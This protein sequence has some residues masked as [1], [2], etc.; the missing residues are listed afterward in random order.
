MNQS[1][2]KYADQIRDKWVSSAQKG[3]S[4]VAG[5]EWAGRLSFVQT[6]HG[7]AILIGVGLVFAIGLVWYRSSALSGGDGSP[8]YTVSQGDLRVQVRERGTLRALRNILISTEIS[9]EAAKVV[10]IVQEGTYVQ[11]G[12]RV[13]EFDKTLF[14]QRID[15]FETELIHTRAELVQA[16]E[17]LRAE[18]AR[19]EQSLKRSED[20]IIL[21]ELNLKDLQEGSGPLK[22]ERAKFEVERAKSKYDTLKKNYE[23]FRLLVKDGYVSQAEVDAISNDLREQEAVLAFAEA[24]YE[25]LIK[26]S[27]PSQVE[28][29]KARVRAAR[30]SVEKL[31]QTSEYTMASRAAGVQ[32]ASGMIQALDFK[33]SMARDEVKRS[34][35]RAPIDGFVIY[36]EIFF[37]SSSEKR[38]IEI[39]DLVLNTQNII[40]IPDTSQM[41]VDIQIREVDIYKIKDSQEVAVRVDAYPDLVLTGKVT[42]IGTLAVERSQE[43]LGGKYFNLQ[44]LLEDTDPRL[45]PGMTAR[46]EILVA[47]E[48][49]VL[50]VPIEAVS[51]SYGKKTVLVSTSDGI[52]QRV[53]E[54]GLSNEDYVSVTR[55]LKL[56]EKVMLVNP[57]QGLR[58]FDSSS[59]ISAVPAV[60]QENRQPDESPNHAP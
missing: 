16:Q 31:K 37:R 3:R 59:G 24:E 47:L 38:K 32:R 5:S 28:A 19:N 56:G 12:D 10:W 40:Q 53:I 14:Q 34:V 39:G 11:K 48:R 41:M 26:Y 29:A 2:Q 8:I 21:A 25:T 20:E 13:V 36:P 50:M 45:R 1:V 22:I 7:R 55:G 52:Q 58:T 6:R 23:E 42:N 15:Q 17:E 54:T 49:D 43:G 35:I 18:Q 27:Y 9:S 44:I 57:A 51:E 4:Y 60:I 46:V 30:E 33:I